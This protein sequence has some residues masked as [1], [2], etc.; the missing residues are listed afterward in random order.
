MGLLIPGFRVQV[1]GAPVIMLVILLSSCERQESTR[2]K[3]GIPKD[4]NKVLILS[5]S[6]HLDP[7]WLKTF[8]EYYEESVSKILKN[9]VKLLEEDEKFYYSIA[10]MIF[11]KR[12]WNDYP[13]L[14][15]KIRKFVREGRLKIVGGGVS[16]PDNLL[17]VGEAIIMDFVQ[18]IKWTKA[19]LGIIPKTAW[20]PDSFGHSPSLP[21][22]LS[23][24]GFKYVGFSRID[25]EPGF[26]TL[27]GTAKKLLEVKSIDFIWKGPSG[28]EVIA[29]WN[30]GKW[31]LGE[32]MWL[33]GYCFGDDIDT[34]IP[35]PPGAKQK[36]SHDKDFVLSKIRNFIDEL[37]PLSPTG[38]VFVPVGCDFQH[39]KPC[40]TKYAKWWN[41][42]EYKKTGVFVTVATFEDYME[43][44]EEKK[45]F[46]PVLEADMTPYWMGFFATRPEL[47][48]LHRM[49]VHTILAGESAWAVLWKLMGKTVQPTDKLWWI[50]GFANHHDFITGTSPDNVYTKEQLPTLENAYKSAK[51]IYDEA[52]MYIAQNVNITDKHITV[53]NPAGER[54][55]LVKV[56]GTLRIFDG[57]NELPTQ[58]YEGYTYFVAKLP[59]WGYKT[60]RAEE[61]ESYFPSSLTFS[62]EENLILESKFWKLAFTKDGLIVRRNG[63]E[64]IRGNWLV[65][66]SDNGGLWRLGHEVEGCEFKEIR[67]IK[68]G[69]VKLKAFGPVFAKVIVGK[70]YIREVTLY[71]L[72][73]RIDFKVTA[74]ADEGKTVLVGFKTKASSVKM[75]I[76]YG[77]VERPFKKIYDPTFWPVVRWIEISNSE[78][79]LTFLEKGMQAWSVDESGEILAIVTRNMEHCG[80]TLGTVGQDSGEHTLE[81]SLIFGN[82]N[83][84]VGYEYNAP[85]LAVVSES[86]GELPESFSIIN[87]KRASTIKVTGGNIIVRT[88]GEEIQGCERTTILKAEDISKVN[89]E[90][91]PQSAIITMICR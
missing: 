2:A 74:R 36:C 16:S 29:H 72:L 80:P 68:G 5:Q 6:S 53:F 37:E 66:A 84:S 62:Q 33:V 23:S 26:M 67:R 65:F 91:T 83:F 56:K 59:P 50:V 82:G 4:A 24:L 28:G 8:E 60:F 86:S 32:A 85:I 11:L 42:T 54:K 22:I 25:G 10:E 7:N 30:K 47:K 35:L 61:G 44:V 77:E 81:Y 55:E 79:S 43:L 52:V 69:P 58:H 64:V 15:E 88:F 19:E 45:E 49:L 89:L 41:E 63:K 17:P 31:I 21:D 75:G 20:F 71:D 18:G 57:E 90:D 39:P 48:K 76:P 38:Y 78:F 70:K 34:P 3:L 9:A 14:K 13:K 46:L 40:L 27:E 1:P 51:K 12:F 73:D 87:A